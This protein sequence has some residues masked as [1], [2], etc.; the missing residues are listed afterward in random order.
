MLIL[1]FNDNPWQLIPRTMHPH[2]PKNL[3]KHWTS[4]LTQTNKNHQHNRQA[5]QFILKIKRHPPTPNF[6]PLLF[7]H[8]PK[9]ILPFIKHQIRLTFIRY[10]WKKILINPSLNIF[11]IHDKTSLTKRTINKTRNNLR[12][13]KIHSPDHSIPKNR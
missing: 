5:F 8:P 12:H 4:N 11:K 13:F 7:I 1:L 6:N 9:T 3:L 10:A 2:D